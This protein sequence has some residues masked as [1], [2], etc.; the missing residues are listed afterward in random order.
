MARETQNTMKCFY[1]SWID[2]NSEVWL[3]SAGQDVQRE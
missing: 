2:N 1:I 3:L